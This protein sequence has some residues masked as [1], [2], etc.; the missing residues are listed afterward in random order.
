MTSWAR[1][2]NTNP[3]CVVVRYRGGRKSHHVGLKTLLLT[4]QYTDPFR[5]ESNLTPFQGIY[6][7]MQIDLDSRTQDNEKGRWY[8]IYND[9]KN[10]L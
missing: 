1:V 4:K 5:Y 6:T 8:S 3:T 2:S 7:V 9:E 10:S